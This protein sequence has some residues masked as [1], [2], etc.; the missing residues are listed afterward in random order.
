MYDENKFD[1]DL[2]MT[3]RHALVSASLHAKMCA[4]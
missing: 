4:G 3:S 1:L 2:L